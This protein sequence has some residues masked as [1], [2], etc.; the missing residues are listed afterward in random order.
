MV[1][2]FE[3]GKKVERLCVYLKGDFPPTDQIIVLYL[4]FLNNEA[5]VRA[6]ANISDYRNSKLVLHTGNPLTVNPPQ[7]SLPEL[8][9]QMKGVA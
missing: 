5:Q 8:Y 7:P 3:E 4:M 1:D 6:T 2:A 9:N